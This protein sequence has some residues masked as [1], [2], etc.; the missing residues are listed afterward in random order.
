MEELQKI[1]E[2]IRQDIDFASEERLIDDG[3]LDS[4][5]IIAIVT[6]VNDAFD[7][8]INVQYLLPENFNSMEAIYRLICKLQDE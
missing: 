5:D 4:I 2:E 1:L 8:D 3:V 6:A 7:V